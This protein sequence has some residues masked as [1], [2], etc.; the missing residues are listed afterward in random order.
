MSKF[1]I[2]LIF[3]WL[4]LVPICQLVKKK[5]LFLL[6]LWETTLKINIKKWINTN[7][8]Q[9]KQ[10]KES[11]HSSQPFLWIRHL[12]ICYF[13][14]FQLLQI[15]LDHYKYLFLSRRYLSGHVRYTCKNISAMGNWHIC[16]D[17]PFTIQPPCLVYSFGWVK[18]F[19]VFHC[20]FLS[21]SF[22]M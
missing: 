17:K 20:F 7:S 19:L 15:C 14:L 8:N 10:E 9:S 4:I 5:Y 2:N 1:F 13:T 16:Q 12:I 18:C 22:N 6:V 21:L 3:S 11:V